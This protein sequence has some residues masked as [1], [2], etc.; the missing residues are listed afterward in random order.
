MER[1]EEHLEGLSPFS[2]GYTA[3]Y[4][5]GCSIPSGG[6]QTLHSCVAESDCRQLHSA[7]FTVAI[8]CGPGIWRILNGVLLQTNQ[9]F[10]ESL[11]RDVHTG[12]F[13]ALFNV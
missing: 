13:K 10:T 9:K 12:L 11:A 5:D 8:G 3:E 1:T 6:L 7:D 2:M 4:A